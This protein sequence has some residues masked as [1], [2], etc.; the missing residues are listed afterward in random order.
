MKKG[1]LLLL[2]LM[3]FLPI[4]CEG[5]LNNPLPSR[6]ALTSHDLLEGSEPGS[7]V[8]Y[9]YFSPR[10][11]AAEPL[12]TFEGQLELLGEAST[13]HIVY[14]QGEEGSTPV[15]GHLPE[16]NFEF[17]QS[18]NHL[19]PIKRGLIITD[20]PEWDYILEPGLT[21]S[22]SG[23][24]G[25]SRAS[26]P[27]FLVAKGGNS[28]LAG[29]MTFL[30]NSSSISKVFY[31]VAQE[32]TVGFR[33][34]MWGLLEAT[35][36]SYPI[37][38]AEFHRQ[39]FKAESAGQIPTRP[40]G[41]LEDMFPEVD[42]QAFTRNISASDLTT[43]GI[44]V[45]GVHFRGGCTTRSG[46]F[47]FCEEIRMASFST[48]KTAFVAVALMRLEEQYGPAVYEQLIRDYLPET[49]DSPGDWSEVTFEDALDMA[50]GNFGSSSFMVDEEGRIFEGFFNVLTYT[51]KI[52]AALDWPHRAPPGTKWVYRSS[53]TFILV[54]AMQNFLRKK[55]G[56]DADIF[57]YVVDEVYLPLGLSSGFLSSAR[58]SDDT[59]QGLPIGASGLWWSPDDVAK[60]GDF[61]NN[62]MGM[63]DG[64]QLLDKDFLLAAL[65]RN[66]DDRGLVIPGGRYNNSL[67]SQTFGAG[68]GFSCTFSVPYMAGY[69][70]NIVAL[71]PNG[72]TY[73]YFSDNRDFNWHEAVLAADSIHPFCQP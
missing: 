73:Y 41:E 58:T 69:S 30:F 63:L 52:T 61:L 54:S 47:P 45:D 56:S 72:I 44:V 8:D 26:L 71:M 39:A 68:E 4:A 28:T 7:L 34:D 60:M 18:G 5:R 37:S 3:G 66:P 48:A 43:W 49:A 55:M 17:I 65:Q 21:W 57:Q 6:E 33:A 36:A 31:Q 15:T 14:W 67:W 62:S 20:H 12:H 70:G 24:E 11:E 23:D 51:E 64:V 40:I 10:G 38:D 16:F 50:T 19:V 25:W 27:F 42:V 2:V 53:D 22:E 1:L 13:G 59:W 35:Y 32:I 9:V 29:V 46:E